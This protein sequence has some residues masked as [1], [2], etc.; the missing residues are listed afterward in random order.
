MCHLMKYPLRTTRTRDRDVF[1]SHRDVSIVAVPQGVDELVHDFRRIVLAAKL[2]PRVHIAPRVEV[3][4]HV[5]VIR[6][7]ENLLNSNA[8]IIEG[9]GE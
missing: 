1:S 8:T 6:G 9:C 2:V 4:H 7:V 3:H 5:V